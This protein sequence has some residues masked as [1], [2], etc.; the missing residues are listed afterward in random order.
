[1][2]ELCSAVTFVDCLKTV[3]AAFERYVMAAYWKNQFLT[4]LTVGDVFVSENRMH[5]MIK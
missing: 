4:S 2:V 3:L 5:K 1:M